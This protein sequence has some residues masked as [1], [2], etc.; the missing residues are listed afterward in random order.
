MAVAQELTG[1]LGGGGWG[2]G[3]GGGQRSI[4]GVD[5]GPKTLPNVHTFSLYL[6]YFSVYNLI[7]ATLQKMY[8][9]SYFFKYFVKSFFL[10][11]CIN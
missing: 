4:L 9:N 1:G 6:F 10:H 11:N 5:D 2:V 7:R 8:T 3:V